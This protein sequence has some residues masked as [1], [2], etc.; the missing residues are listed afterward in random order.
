MDPKKVNAGALKD[1][2]EKMADNPENALGVYLFKGY[3]IH[4][5]KYMMTGSQRYAQLY[6]R[7][8]NNGLCVYCGK[9]VASKNPSTGKLYR[10][11][12]EHRN[13]I[14]RNRIRKK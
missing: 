1:I 14:D 3:R 4:I 2:V 11:C 7:R 9:K 5:S 13:S 10:L 12:E 6:K 8:R